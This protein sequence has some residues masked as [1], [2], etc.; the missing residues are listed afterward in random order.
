MGKDV[1]DLRKNN[2]LHGKG[3]STGR[4]RYAEDSLFI[5]DTCSSAGKNSSCADICK[6]LC[7]EE[8]T[9]SIQPLVE[10]WFY[11]FD[12]TVIVSNTGTAV[13]Y[14]TGTAR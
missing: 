11:G 10:Q 12:G 8:F 1:P 9:E 5:N 13:Y 14:D 4:S 2:L 7:P 6:T 3:D